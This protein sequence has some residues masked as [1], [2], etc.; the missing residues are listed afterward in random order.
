MNGSRILLD[1]NAIIFLLDGNKHLVNTLKNAEWIGISIISC[2]EFKAYSGLNKSDGQL[3]DEFTQ[4]VEIIGILPSDDELIDRVI[5]F[6]RK[7]R[8]KI[9][10]AIIASTALTAN[11][12]LLTADRDFEKIKELTLVKWKME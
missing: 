11:A 6:R 3:F 1:T 9:P 2:I 5:R 7:Y 8:I 10:D 4:R 12:A